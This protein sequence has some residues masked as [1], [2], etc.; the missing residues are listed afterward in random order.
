MMGNEM[1]VA[2]REAEKSAAELLKEYGVESAEHIRLED[3]A[4]DLGVRIV[5]GPLT[6]AA[7]R[8]VRYGKHGTIRVS[9]AEEYSTRKRFSIAH[10][11]GH[12]VL[13]H[14]Y[15]LEYVSSDLDM[16][17]WYQADG[18]ERVANAFAGELLLP[19]FL[20]EKRCDVRSVDFNPVRAIADEF[21]ASLTATAI[22]FVRFCPEACAILFSLGSKIRWVYKSKSFWPYIKTGKLLDK[23][24][25][26]WDF[27]N[28]KPLHEEP[29]DV[30]ADAW[31]DSDRLGDIEEV[32]EHSLGFSNL[33]G[34]L[35]LIWMRP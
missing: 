17:D 24:T 14:G 28:G 22:R 4:Y 12:F 23:R 9:N 29:E 7:A 2:F 13:V 26:A 34:V 25:L 6:G 19:R 33:G 27:F 18:I 16:H 3:I 31:L 8:L 15:S 5:E 11:L 20:V 35:T 32:V 1:P 21:Q 10:E 30:D